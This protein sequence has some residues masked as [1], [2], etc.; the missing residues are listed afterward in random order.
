MG[1]FDDIGS[2]N[3]FGERGIFNPGGSNFLGFDDLGRTL[4]LN[5]TPRIAPYEMDPAG[6]NAAIAMLGQ[7]PRSVPGN[8]PIQVQSGFGSLLGT[9]GGSA[10]QQTQNMGGKVPIGQMA[11]VIDPSTYY[12]NRAQYDQTR[13][14]QVDANGMLRDAAMGNVPSVAELQLRM[15]QEALARQAMGM[16][17]SG[18]GN[19]AASRL[20]AMNAGVLGGQQLNQQQAALRAA[21]MAQARGAYSGALAGLAGQDLGAASQAAQIAQTQD[22]L[23]MRGQIANQGAGLQF[24]GLGLQARGLD[25][26]QRRA[27]LSSLGG[28]DELG[29]NNYFRGAE[30]NTGINSENRGRRAQFF[31]GMFEAGAKLAMP[32]GGG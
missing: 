10:A 9:P 28:Y 25:D 29:A 3:P 26:E 5:G 15:G 11:T 18:R 30:I 14:Q 17:A 6:R 4:G 27:A 12:G 1:L 22:E 7:D 20:A 21:E 24:S 31:G 13:G 16:A 32:R 19:Q 23:A 8:A 2:L